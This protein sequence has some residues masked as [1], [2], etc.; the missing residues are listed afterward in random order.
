[1]VSCDRGWL[2]IHDVGGGDCLLRIGRDDSGS[3]AE[4]QF[5]FR[6]P[7]EL[8]VDSRVVAVEWDVRGSGVGEAFK[9]DLSFWRDGQEESKLITRLV[10]FIGWGVT[11]GARFR[12][13]LITEKQ[14]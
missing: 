11:R 6:G 13:S 7:V 8:L 2:F 12:F 1:L 3:E 4:L 9:D 14:V 5:R 10:R